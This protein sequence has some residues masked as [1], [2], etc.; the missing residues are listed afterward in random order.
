MVEFGVGEG[1]AFAPIFVS[2]SHP[3]RPQVERDQHKRSNS[4][5]DVTL[6][7]KRSLFERTRSLWP[8]AVCHVSEAG[9]CNALDNI[10]RRLGKQL[11]GHANDCAQLAAWAFHQAI[12]ELART[13]SAAPRAA[14]R[15]DEIS[16]E[17]FDWWM[18]ENLSDS[19]WAE[20][21]MEYLS[22]SY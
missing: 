9:S 14:L 13:K 21:R 4:N 6:M 15:R 1:A 12:S 18:R 22:A 2:P 17:A 7:D 11:G 19:S 5:A 3:P 10:Y 16:F 20:V 8:D